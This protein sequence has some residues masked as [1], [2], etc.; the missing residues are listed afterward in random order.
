[1]LDFRFVA[2]IEKRRKA[3][4]DPAAAG[5]QSSFG[6]HGGQRDKRTKESEAARQKSPGLVCPSIYSG[7]LPLLVRTSEIA[8]VK[9]STPVLGTMMLLRRP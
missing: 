7:V 5:R 9:S 2:M 4:V 1:M 6:R 3:S 8:A